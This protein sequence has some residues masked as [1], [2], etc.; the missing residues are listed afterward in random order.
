MGI[1]YYGRYVDDMI[2]VDTSKKHLIEVRERIRLWL[3]ERG[4]VLHPKKK[5]I[6][7]ITEKVCCLLTVPRI[8]PG[9]KIC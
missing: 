5:C 6:C 7:N 4:L 3:S 2:L 1:K 8:L 9:R